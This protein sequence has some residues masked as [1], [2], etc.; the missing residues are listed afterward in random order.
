MA[1]F[2]QTW[3][4]KPSVSTKISESKEGVSIKLFLRGDEGLLDIA[5]WVMFGTRG[6][7]TIP[8]TPRPYPLRY[9]GTFTPKTQPGVLQSTAGFEGP[10]IFIAKEV[11][12]PGIKA[13]K[14]FE[15]IIQKH[16]GRFYRRMAKQT[17]KGLK[18]AVLRGRS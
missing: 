3:D 1:Q 10:P 13:R 9:P 8:K 11:E 7:Y 15:V 6:P 14:P 4:S 5:D 18:N 16:A 12:H 17:A 2:F